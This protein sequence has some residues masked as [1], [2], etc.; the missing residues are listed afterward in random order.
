MIH[1]NV[2]FG[3][4]FDDITNT[5]IGQKEIGGYGFFSTFTLMITSLMAVYRD[6]GVVVENID[7]TNLLKN[8]PG[9]KKD[10]YEHFF[11]TNSS[12]EIDIEPSIIPK[13]LS[14]D[15]HHSIY[16]ESSCNMF[17]PFFLRYFNP[18][19]NIVEKITI[20]MNKYHF[21]SGRAISV[22]YRDTDK[23]TDFGCFNHISPALFRK[24]ARELKESDENLKVWIQTEN[25]G[26]RDEFKNSLN[27][28]FFEETLVSNTSKTPLF[29]HL[30]SNKL[31]WSE[32]YVASLILI[33]QSKYLITY[34]GNSSFFLYLCRGTTK[35]LY[36]EKTFQNTNINDFFS[37]NNE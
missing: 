10:M 27:A 14:P 29:L 25:L 6:F 16:S 31:E 11:Y 21:I 36:Q 19:L 2:C 18:S 12:V 3:Y 20:L 9:G 26:V 37:I 8:L 24:I 35:N 22:V 28:G 34:T 33:S 32:F 23:W 30:D 5:L 4:D 1:K 17:T 7:G 13:N 15:I